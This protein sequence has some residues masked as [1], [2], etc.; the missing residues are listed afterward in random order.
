[1]IINLSP[2]VSSDELD[3]FINGET[4]TINGN[5][6]DFSVIPDGAT[7]PADA[8]ED[9]YI[10]GDIERISGVINLTLLF[11]INGDSTESARFPSPINQTSGQVE[12]PS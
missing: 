11:P 2:Q 1:M 5:E 10:I 8:I 3:L 12:L 9:D 4:L 7:L 6:Y